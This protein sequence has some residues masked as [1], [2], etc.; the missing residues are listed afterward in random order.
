[1][2]TITCFDISGVKYSILVSIFP[3]IVKFVWKKR[4]PKAGD[5]KFSQVQTTSCFYAGKC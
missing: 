5:N 1:M 2:F 3:N 4:T